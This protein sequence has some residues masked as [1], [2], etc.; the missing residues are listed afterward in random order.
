[1]KLLHRRQFLHLA[2]GAA[3]LP[4]ASGIILTHAI[5]TA[6]PQAQKTIRIV[7]PFAAG[8]GSDILARLLGEQIGRERGVTIVIENRPGAGTVIATE[9]VARA[10]PDGGTVL[11]VANSFV[12]NPA[13]QKR[14]Y[15]PLTSFEAV[16]MLTRSPN[17]VAVNNASPYRTLVDLIDA[18][19]ARPGDVAMAF[20]G[21][22]TGQ[23]IG[24]EK[25]KRAAGINMIP[26]TFPGAAPA[27][28]ALLGQHVA[29]L[30]VNYPS[31]AEQIEA[32]KLRALATM[33]RSRI[34]TL[35]DVPTVGELGYPNFEEDVWF[36][37]VTPARAPRNAI[38]QFAGWFG[39]A[40]LSDQ[41][42]PKLAAQGFSA[43][44]TCG[45]DFA[46]FLQKQYDDYSRIIRESNM[47]GE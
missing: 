21:P 47:K 41:L 43:D 12:I 15:D 16:C 39:P 6:W 18:A 40:V 31:A 33:S 27:V 11:M 22:A 24:Y 4:I 3:A 42:K 10:A 13:L 20:N 29:A 26:V 45:H 8:G 35:P 44:G 19:R 2:G 38:A 17:V 1:M 30:V 34:E 14:N 46:M 7:V 32:G 23:Q 25:L 28:N 9:A 36:G 37:V 5:E